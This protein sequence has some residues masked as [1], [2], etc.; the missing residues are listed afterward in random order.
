MA[1]KR[2]KSNTG[3]GCPFSREEMFMRNR[4]VESRLRTAG[5]WKRYAKRHPDAVT[6]GTK[7]AL[8]E[9]DKQRVLLDALKSISE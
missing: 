1:T 5:R 2:S 9:S 7:V 6:F 8:M 3:Q 4:K